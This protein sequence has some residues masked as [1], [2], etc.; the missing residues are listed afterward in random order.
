MRVI[1]GHY[2][3]RLLIPPPTDNTRPILDR[4]KVSLFDWLGSMLA[5]PG[6]LPPLAVLDLFC[7]TGSLG[8]EALSRG[9]D[10]CTFVEKDRPTARC[11]QQNLD[12]LGVSPS[13]F[14]LLTESAEHI[15]CAPPKHPEGYD[16]IFL[17]PPYALSEDDRPD[18]LMP[19]I[20][21]RLGDQVPVS[22]NAVALWR[23]DGHVFVPQFLPQG[24][25]SSERRVWGSM[26]VTLLT[27]SP[28][29]PS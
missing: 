29:V 19:R 1:A 27:R 18:S 12:T 7:G 16:L 26:A 2:R 8:I 17:D 25:H 14:R 9:A 28:Q 11:L 5:Q 6:A 15:R 13:H 20:L 23:T 4:V 21:R 10:Y 3:G 24:W 22:T